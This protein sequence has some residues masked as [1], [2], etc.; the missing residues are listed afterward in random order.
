[1]EMEEGQAEG[2]E[3]HQMRNLSW[4]ALHLRIAAL[5]QSQAAL[6]QRIAAL[7][8]VPPT[9]D[10]ESLG[11]KVKVTFSPWRVL[12][13]VLVLGAGAYK[14]VATLQGNTA[15]PTAVDWTVGVLWSLMCVRVSTLLGHA[16]PQYNEVCIGCLSWTIQR[17]ANQT[18]SSVTTCLQFCSLCLRIL[19]QWDYL[20]VSSMSYQ[21]KRTIADSN[22]G[23][24]VIALTTILRYE[25]AG[26]IPFVV[27]WCA[28]T[29]GV[30][31]LVLFPLARRCL[32]STLRNLVSNRQLPH[33]PCS[34]KF[35]AS[36]WSVRNPPGLCIIGLLL[37]VCGPLHCK[38]ISIL[39]KSS[40]QTCVPR[41]D[42]IFFKR[43]AIPLPY[44]HD[45]GIFR[46]WFDS[47]ELQD[48]DWLP[49]VFY[50]YHISILKCSSRPH[51]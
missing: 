22:V 13:S 18:G 45:I 36:D 29:S 9:L 12:N 1:M 2:N 51:H 47:N 6:I 17:V 37:M 4:M 5:E 31:F 39:G 33:F 26:V 7:E 35:V 15:G 43:R 16:D 32:L 49:S 42:S 30:G 20:Q 3:P 8:P 50:I 27:V 21:R 40:N 28:A 11:Q 34:F 23:I 25:P 14:A 19:S 46:F 10:S 48:A 44:S 38:W 24:M 41:A